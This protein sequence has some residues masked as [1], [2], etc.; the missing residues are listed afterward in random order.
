MRLFLPVFLLLTWTLTGGT[1]GG[2]SGFRLDLPFVAQ[3]KDACGAA[4]VAMVIGW[5][6]GHGFELERGFSV[7]AVAIHAA[8]SSR[9]KAGTEAREMESYLSRAGFR[10]FAF[11]GNWN[12]V[13]EHIKNG[14]P[15]IAAIQ[16]RG[17]R[18]L[19]YVVLSGFDT[20][21]ILLHD[22]ARAPFF[23]MSR[24]DFEAQWSRSGRWTL[25][26]L[27]RQP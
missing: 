13:T 11:P 1:P 22:P 14:R 15:L 10:V 16:P 24:A 2:D 25:L 21:T 6:K 5:W 3:T 26:A 4:T 23:S 18:E 12:D 7:D 8:I 17:Q 27:P 9:R 19:H 20:R